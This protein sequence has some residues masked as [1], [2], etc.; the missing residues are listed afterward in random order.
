MSNVILFPVRS[1]EP[2]I[3]ELDEDLSLDLVTAVDVAIRDLR[4]LMLR[5]QGD[6]TGRRQAHD[7]LDMLSRA[8]EGARQHG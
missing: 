4:D 7:C 8:L 2:V 6:D 3:E 5:L 1:P